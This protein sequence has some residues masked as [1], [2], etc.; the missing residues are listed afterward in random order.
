[1]LESKDFYGNMTEDESSYTR[2]GIY[3]KEVACRILSDV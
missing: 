2:L 1:M 3:L